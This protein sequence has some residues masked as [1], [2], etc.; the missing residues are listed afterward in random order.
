MSEVHHKTLGLEPGADDLAIK[1]A[2]KALALKTHPDH[3]PV[4]DANEKMRDLIQAR[5]A[6]LAPLKGR[7]ALTLE[8]FA[9][10]LGVSQ[11]SASA[12]PLLSSLA[13]LINQDR[14]ASIVV[15]ISSP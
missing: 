2:F 5:R 3:H 8:E 11:E 4:L 14:E 7:R 10:G 1:A 6:L 9:K 12:E 15:R 13:R